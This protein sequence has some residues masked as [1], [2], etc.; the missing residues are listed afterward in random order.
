MRNRTVTAYLPSASGL[1]LLMISLAISAIG[2]PLGNTL[3]AAGYPS[4][5]AAINLVHTG[6]HIIASTVMIPIWGFMGAIYA[7]LLSNAVSIPVNVWV[8]GSSVLPV[9]NGNQGHQLDFSAG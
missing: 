7:A 2:H 5:P 4:L 8:L 6:I 3:V 9:A 1:A